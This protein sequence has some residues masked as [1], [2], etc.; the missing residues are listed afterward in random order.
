MTD[1]DAAKRLA[2]FMERR[3]IEAL[4]NSDETPMDVLTEAREALRS[5]LAGER[6]GLQADDPREAGGSLLD[7]GG[8]HDQNK[9]LYDTR[10]AI[11]PEEFQFALAHYTSDGEPMPDAVA[12]VV[13][14]RINRPPD[15]DVAAKAPAEQVQ[16]L[17]LMSWEAAADIVVDIQAL[18][19]RDGSSQR[20]RELLEERW[21]RLE[22]KGLTRPRRAAS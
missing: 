10:S 5:V 12:M 21:K 13:R 18:A 20:L 6:Q 9:V 7:A 3:H 17:H 14:G 11:L 1:P 16:H 15:D 19:G 2:F 4:L 8:P 22:E